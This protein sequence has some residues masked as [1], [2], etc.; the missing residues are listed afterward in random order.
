MNFAKF[1]RTHFLQNTSGGPPKCKTGCES[2]DHQFNKIATFLFSI[3][4]PDYNKQWIRFV[5]QVNW[6]PA[7]HS[8]LWELDF[9]E[10]CVNLTQWCNL[11]WQLNPV[12]IIYS[13][14]LLKSPSSCTKKKANYPKNISTR[15]HC[16]K[17][18]RIPSFSSPYFPAFSLNTGKYGLEKLQIRTLFLQRK[19]P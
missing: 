6:E 15:R 5:N 8:V 9:K 12:T 13:A 19:F 4:K 2:I 17:S 1:L 7:P 10:S 3:K 16:G 14:S 11:K 18:V